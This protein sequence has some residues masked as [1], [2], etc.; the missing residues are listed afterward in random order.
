MHPR[1]PHD[2]AVH[3]APRSARTGAPRGPRAPRSASKT[4]VRR[5]QFLCW[6]WSRLRLCSRTLRGGRTSHKSGQRSC[7]SCRVRL[8]QQLQ[9]QSYAAV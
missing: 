5:P 4:A 7:C 3:R 6:A 1:S 2:R 8:A 9:H